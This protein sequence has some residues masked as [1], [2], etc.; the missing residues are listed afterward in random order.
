MIPGV[1]GSIPV[2][3]PSIKEKPLIRKVQRLFSFRQKFSCQIIELNSLSRDGDKLV[4]CL[5]RDQRI[6]SGLLS[7]VDDMFFRGVDRFTDPE[8]VKMIDS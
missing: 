2:C 3:R 4:P 8:F 6:Y 5:A 1:T 7:P